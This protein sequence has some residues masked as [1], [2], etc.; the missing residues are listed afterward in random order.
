MGALV[1]EAVLAKD[2][3]LW[4]QNTGYQAI[5]LIFLCLSFRVK[6]ENPYLRC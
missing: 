4:F 5:S 2:D 6:F 1:V 3:S